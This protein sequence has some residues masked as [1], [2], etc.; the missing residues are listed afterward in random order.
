[1]ASYD[2]DPRWRHSGGA[3][4]WVVSVAVQRQALTVIGLCL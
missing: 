3:E 1:M 2:H 4:D